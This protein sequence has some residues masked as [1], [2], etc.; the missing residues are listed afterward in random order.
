[1]V[2]VAE[3]NRTAARSIGMDFSVT[4]GKFSF[5]QITGGLLTGGSRPG[6]PIG[7]NLPVSI[8]NGNVLLA[9]QALRT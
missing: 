6:R 9:I 7:G 2:S 1:M 3:V 8:D 4:N 5:A